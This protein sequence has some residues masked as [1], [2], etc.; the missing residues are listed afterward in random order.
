MDNTGVW[1]L[2]PIFKGKDMSTKVSMRDLL[3]AGSHFGHQTRFWNPKMA[4]FIFGSRNKIHIINLDYTVKAFNEAL[5]YVNKLASKNNKVLFVGTKRAAGTIIR[6]EAQRAGMPYVDHRWLGGMLTNWKTLR[7]SINRLKDLE[8]QAE[9]GTFAKLTKRE[10]LERTRE[11]EKLERSLGGVKNMGGLPDALFIVDVDHE[12]IAIKEAK[13]LGIPVIG[14]VDTNSSP[15]N[16]D[17]VIPANDDAIRAIK[18]YVSTM[19]DAVLA[20]KE[21]AESQKPA[22]ERAAKPE[23]KAAAPVATEAAPA[24]AAAETKAEPA[25][26]ADYSKLTVAQLKEEI[27]TRGLKADS[28]AL[29]ADLVAVL[30]ESD[31]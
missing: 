25:E 12:S 27:E 19:A 22:S 23:T 15:D 17:Y 16:V 20:G 24:E 18:L 5:T 6:E 2:N 14:I 9:D 30:E 10:A 13:N 8:R 7:Q 3:A 28:K 1:R 4:P 26:K 21:Y 29:K 31:K 11:M